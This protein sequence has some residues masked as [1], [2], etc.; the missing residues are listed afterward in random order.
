MNSDLRFVID[1]AMEASEPF[2]ELSIESTHGGRQSIFDLLKQEDLS[3]EAAETEKVDLPPYLYHGSMYD[4]DELQ[5]GFNHSGELVRWDKSEDNTWLYTSDK[6]DDAVMLG[7]SSAIEKK[8]KLDRYQWDAKTR[9]M[10]ITIS[11]DLTVKDIYDLPV[12]LYAIKPDH[13][14]GWMANYNPVN[15]IN[16]EYKTQHKVGFA[17]KTRI[18]VAAVLRGVKIKIVRTPDASFE[19][20]SDLIR[21]VKKLFS[22]PSQKESRNTIY[23]PRNPDLLDSKKTIE[24]IDKFFGNSSWLKAQKFETEVSSEGIG[25]GLSIDGKFETSNPIGWVEHG[26]AEYEKDFEKYS[27]WLKSVDAEVQRIHKKAESEIMAAIQRDDA[28]AV[29]EIGRKAIADFNAI[30]MPMKSMAPMNHIGGDQTYVKKDAESPYDGILVEH[31]E[32]KATVPAKIPA[33]SA[34]DISKAAKLVKELLADRKDS[35]RLYQRWLDFKDGSDFVDAIY[36]Y[37]Y[38]LYMDY[39]DIYYHQRVDQEIA[40][41]FPDPDYI[42]QD[43]SI[44]LL[45]WMDR[46]V[47]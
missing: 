17:M 40:Y 7:I 22:G 44:A 18:D 21:G 39:F 42:Y 26:V 14:D 11:D 28:A 41:A 33:L 15:G 38:D 5:P 10:T 37:D 8:F 35:N 30:K 20:F 6:R 12:Y 43:I 25:Q 32:I 34:D 45:T 24:Y 3:L 19:S 16:G 4:Q 31:R 13:R 27:G 36:D 46:S 23:H 29:K 2:D 9:S 47:K 1:L